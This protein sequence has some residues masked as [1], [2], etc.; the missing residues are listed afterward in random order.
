M[1]C[2]VTFQTQALLNLKR[3][4]QFRYWLEGSTVAP[5]RPRIQLDRTELSGS[6]RVS[7]GF[8]FN[9][10][11]RHD[12]AK[13]FQLQITNGMSYTIAA[14]GPIPEFEIEAYSAHSAVGQVR[15]YRVLTA[16]LAD[17]QL[18]TKKLEVLMPTPKEADISFIPQTIWNSLLGP[19]KQAYYVMQQT[20]S[21]SHN[22]IRFVGLKDTSLRL[23]GGNAAGTLART[24]LAPTIFTWLTKVKSADNCTLFPK[25]FPCDNGNVELWHHMSHEKEARAWMS[26]ALAEIAQASGIDIVLNRA[27]AN[28]MF[29]NP[30]KV[31][32]NLAK[33]QCG[34][35]LPAKL[36]M[37]FCPP[38]G[39]PTGII[40]FPT[41]RQTNFWY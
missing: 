35:S 24:A 16:T 13:N 4:L 32:Q 6:K 40:T 25:V 3:N 2:R 37:N 19:K 14:T 12:M 7:A 27:A 22:A 17:L 20:F 36:Y 18:L 23:K 28:A 21:I 41:R 10:M 9:V 30:D 31:W 39:P 38:T 26:T 33:L 29:N 1:K 15:L 5:L 11:A 8:F 34:V